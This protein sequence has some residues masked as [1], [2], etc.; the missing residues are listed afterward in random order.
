MLFRSNIRTIGI[1]NGNLYCTSASSVYQGVSQIGSGLPT[2]ATSIT[3]LA[4][5]PSAVGPSNYDFFFA[6]PNTVYVA[7]DRATTAGGGIQKWTQTGGTWTLAYTLAPTASSCRH[8]TGSVSNGVTTL[9]ATST[10]ASG[11]G[12]V[13][14]SASEMSGVRASSTVT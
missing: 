8:L 10:T 6:D 3:L 4:G 14:A 1:A 9:Y 7:D 12:A 11:S 2:Q 13:A 5:F